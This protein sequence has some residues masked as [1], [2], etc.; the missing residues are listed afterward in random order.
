[1]KE[2][3]MM[4]TEQIE[5]RLKSMR[6]KVTIYRILTYGDLAAIILSLVITKILLIALGF[7]IIALVF[8]IPAGQAIRKRDEIKNL[9]GESVINGVIRDVLGDDL[10]YNPVGALNPGSVV[11]PFRYECLDGKY[12]IKTVYNGV[13]IEMSNII[14]Y[15]VYEEVDDVAYRGHQENVLFRGPWLICSFGKKPACDVYIS[16]WTKRDRESMKSN[17]KIDNEQFGSRFC[18]RAEN[19]PWHYLFEHGK[20]YDD[21]E[22]LRQKF[23]GELHWLTD[24]INTLN[25]TQRNV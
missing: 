6:I 3:N 8:G 9:L 18:V 14:L 19:P 4:T 7:L 12:H 20:D 16:E 23:S 1:M 2:K 15:E 24:I 25:V 17:V 21:A 22:R 11:V 10:E 5:A 13:N